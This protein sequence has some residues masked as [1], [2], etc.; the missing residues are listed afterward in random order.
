MQLVSDNHNHIIYDDITSMV[1]SASRKD[2]ESISITEH[3]SQF[4]KPRSEI[5]F[6]SVHTKG[7]IFES[8]EEYLSE[9]KKLN[10]VENAPKVN[11]GL[12]VDY[13]P[14]FEKQI[15]NFVLEKK[16]DLL[17]VSVHEL[18][19]NDDI[20]SRKI[21]FDRESSARRWI[22]YLELEKSA[23]QS[24]LI[25]FDVLTHPIR[26]A[27]STPTMPKN[28]DELLLE[29]GAVAK[30]E[31]KALE[32]NG[33]DITRDYEFVE[34]LASACSKSSCNVSFGSDAHHPNEIGRGMKKALELIDKYKLSLKQFCD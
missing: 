7:R 17:L 29:L 15:S 8:F 22:E 16:W 31:G 11:K 2:L 5:K 9:F 12:E 10:N 14:S 4:R 26:L 27:R 32:L 34:R 18:V 13:N 1:S 23:L 25:L 3:I 28:F 6:G 24:D 30:K 19:N 20:E 21:S 33:N